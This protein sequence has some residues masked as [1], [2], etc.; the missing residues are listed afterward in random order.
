[1]GFTV[2]ME[3][4]LSQMK[5]LKGYFGQKTHPEYEQYNSEDMNPG[6]I[7]GREG[8]EL[9]DCGCDVTSYFRLR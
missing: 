3:T 9:P 2:I 8:D 7:K 4:N 6:L 5:F 1:M